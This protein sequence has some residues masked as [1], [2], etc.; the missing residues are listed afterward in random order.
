MSVHRLS[1]FIIVWFTPQMFLSMLYG[2]C[3]IFALFVVLYI[4]FVYVSLKMY[5]YPVYYPSL[6]ALVL[7]DCYSLI[8]FAS[9]PS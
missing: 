3:L 4:F 6:I 5:T 2:V 7:F 1:A 9:H 8:Y